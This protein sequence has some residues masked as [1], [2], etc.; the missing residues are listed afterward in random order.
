MDTEHRPQI[1]SKF[2]SRKGGRGLG[3]RINEFREMITQK[4]PKGKMV[5]VKEYWSLF[6][7]SMVKIT[8]KV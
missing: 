8:Q 7:D 3:I 5:E 1:S 4:V 6:K 2:K